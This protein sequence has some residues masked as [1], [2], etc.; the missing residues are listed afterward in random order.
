MHA[1]MNNPIQ[2]QNTINTMSAIIPI[3]KLICSIIHS[4]LSPV[5]IEYNILEKK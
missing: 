5:R 2:Q 4:N 3:I 1:H